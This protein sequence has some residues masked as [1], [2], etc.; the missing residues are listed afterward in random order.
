MFNLDP[1]DQASWLLLDEFA[2]H[3]LFGLLLLLLLHQSHARAAAPVG[4][5][6]GTGAAQSQGQAIQPFYVW[7]FRISNDDTQRIKN[8]VKAKKKCSQNLLSHF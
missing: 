2:L 8:K 4:R 6:F 5:L 1:G 7:I 3:G